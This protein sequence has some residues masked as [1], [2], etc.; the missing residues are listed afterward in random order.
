MAYGGFAWEVNRV[1]YT[2]SATDNG[3]FP[4]SF[5]WGNDCLC[6]VFLCY[7]YIS[8]ETTLAQ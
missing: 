4:V 3:V 1:R 2:P 8:L 7:H 5:Y 6:I